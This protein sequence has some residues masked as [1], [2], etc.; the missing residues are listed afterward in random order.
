MAL[1]V[2]AKGG[3]GGKQWDDGFNYECVT[4]LHVRGGR[5]GIQFIKFEYVKAGETTVGLIHG[6][7]DRCGLTQTFEINHLEKE[8]L[9]S[10]GVTAM[11]RLGYPG[12]SWLYISGC[13]VLRL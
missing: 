6:V 5:E 11:N 12:L 10:V 13:H 2:E 1:N 9:I 3:N 4:K 8:H 7:S